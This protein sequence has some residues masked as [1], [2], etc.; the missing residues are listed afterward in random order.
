MSDPTAPPEPNPPAPQRPEPVM[1]AWVIVRDDSSPGAPIYWSGLNRHYSD[2]GWSHNHQHAVRFAQ[3][4]DAEKVASE[5]RRTTPCHVEEHSWFVS[6]PPPVAAPDPFCPVHGPARAS[7][8]AAAGCTCRPVPPSPPPPEAKRFHSG[9]QVMEHYVPGYKRPDSEPS[10]YAPPPAPDMEALVDEMRSCANLLSD[11]PGVP[12]ARSLLL[13]AAET[14]SALSRRLQ[15]AEKELE[16]HR[17]FQR[18]VNEA[19]NSG[20]GS[21]RP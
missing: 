1:T 5:V 8:H 2:G 6:A 11:G 7:D 3:M 17:S 21:Y 4:Q 12:W 15:G 13:K 10:P 18:S 16:G 9:E 19:L 14:F 20:D